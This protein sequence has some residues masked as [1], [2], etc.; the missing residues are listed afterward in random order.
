MMR[1][2]DFAA[3]KREVR[4]KLERALQRR[5]PLTIGPCSMREVRDGVF[6]VHD[7]ENDAWIEGFVRSGRLR[8]TAAKGGDG[9][10]DTPNPGA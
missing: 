5:V 6:R 9:I 7:Y 3:Y 10:I 8:V 4:A 1:V 2:R